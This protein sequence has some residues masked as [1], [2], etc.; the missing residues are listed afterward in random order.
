MMAS[1]SLRS[2]WSFFRMAT[3]L[4]RI[5]VSKPLALASP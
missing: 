1:S 5:F 3:I 2:A 4:R